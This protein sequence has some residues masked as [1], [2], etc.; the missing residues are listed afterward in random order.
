M[1]CDEEAK[2]LIYIITYINEYIKRVYI[3]GLSL[4]DC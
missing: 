4:E 2:E 1:C 3:A